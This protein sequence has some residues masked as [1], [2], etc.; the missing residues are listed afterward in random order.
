MVADIPLRNVFGNN[1][2]LAN[3]PNLSMGSNFAVIKLFANSKTSPL[4]SG[5]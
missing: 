4:V 3:F 5:Q 2:P 1:E